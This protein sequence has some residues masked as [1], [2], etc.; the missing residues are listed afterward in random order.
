MIRMPIVP[1]LKLSPSV[2][3]TKLIG[4]FGVSMVSKVSVSLVV[5]GVR[6]C[7]DQIALVG[8]FRER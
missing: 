7:L 3:L 8:W 5:F 2:A 1:T 6:Y 4:T